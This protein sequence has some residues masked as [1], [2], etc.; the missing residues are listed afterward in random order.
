MTMTS[1]WNRTIVTG[2]LA[3]LTA[4][5]ALAG[6]SLAATHAARV[7]H[8][9]AVVKVPKPTPGSDQYGTPGYKTCATQAKTAYKKAVAK[10]AA[11]LNAVLHDPASTLSA[12]AKARKQY[13]AAVA[14]AKAKYSKALS[15][16]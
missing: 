7:V 10:A 11:R 15:H 13:K 6:T 12:K 8:A 4:A 14:K 1:S 5:F 9:A 2:S 3:A 16:C